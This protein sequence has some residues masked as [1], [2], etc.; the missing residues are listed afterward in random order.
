[1]HGVRDQA[2]AE[3]F[4]EFNGAVNGA[5]QAATCRALIHHHPGAAWDDFVMVEDERTGQVVSTICLIPWRLALAGIPLTAAMLEMVVT[6]PDYR[7]RGLVREQI[8]RFHRRA[9]QQAV[10]LCIIEGIPYYYRQFG[11]AYALDHWAADSLATGQIPHSPLASNIRLRR[12]APADIPALMPLYAQSFAS[13]P[14]HTVRSADEWVYLIQGASYPVYVVEG[15]GDGALLGYVCGW[16]SAETVWL[17]ESGFTDAAT[18][19]AVLEACKPQASLIRLGWPA[20]SALVQVG[21][22]LGSGA[23]VGDQ[24]LVRF[25]DL[26]RLIHKLGPIWTARLAAAG[27]GSLTVELILNLYQTAYRLRFVDGALAGVDALGFVDASMGADGGD[28][29]IPPDAFTRLLLGYRSLD[30]LRDAWP[31][32]MIRPACR[33]LLDALFPRVASYVWMPYMHCGHLQPLSF[34]P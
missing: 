27:Y 3:A 13:L 29:C 21:R 25:P 6:H 7:R 2:D 24:W 12:A 31:D 1:M 19:L 18:A 34:A 16:Q 30:E 26:A 10:D 23:G 32:I 14:L 28:L 8:E 5:D 17:V 9:A 11:Y 4:A 20:Q 15:R 22:S 33:H